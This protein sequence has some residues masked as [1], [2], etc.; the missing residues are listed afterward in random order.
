MT[1]VASLLVVAGSSLCFG[2]TRL[3]RSSG[4]K[5]FVFWRSWLVFATDFGQSLGV[6]SQAVFVGVALALSTIVLMWGGIGL[7]LASLAFV[8]LPRL[9]FRLSTKRRQEQFTE[10]LPSAFDTLAASL[11]AGQSLP[12]ALAAVA[13][14]FAAPCGPFFSGI[15][16][17][18]KWGEPTAVALRQA[19][20]PAPLVAW[21]SFVGAAETLL[22][23]GGNLSDVARQS[24]QALRRRQRALRR[25]QTLTAQGRYQ[26]WIVAAL[27]LFLVLAL[28][29]LEPGLY[30]TLTGSLT[31][32][33]LLALAFLLDAVAVWLMQRILAL[34]V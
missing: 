14:R 9:W 29:T 31:G 17:R 24:A 32:W 1:L 6:S 26:A 21:F 4:G 27:P 15:V 10:Q 12:Q 19:K 23:A 5:R 20:P 28:R 25:L 8:G 34:D 30:A 18:I 11:A 13:D 22:S 33:L 2:A 7:L 3:Q 16:E